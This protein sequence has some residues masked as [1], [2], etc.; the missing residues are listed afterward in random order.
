MIVRRSNDWI[1]ARR[2]NPAASIALY[3]QLR[4]TRA[5]DAPAAR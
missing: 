3:R 5:G 2:S 4:D 1:V